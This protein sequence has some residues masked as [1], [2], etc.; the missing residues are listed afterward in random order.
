MISTSI[1]KGGVR[2]RPEEIFRTHARKRSRVRYDRTAE[3]IY[4]ELRRRTRRELERLDGSGRSAAASLDVS[5]ELV[6]GVLANRTRSGSCLERL[7]G[8][9]R[10]V[11]YE[12][13][14][15]TTNGQRPETSIERLL[16]EGH[17]TFERAARTRRDSE[18]LRRESERIG[19]RTPKR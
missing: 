19:K 17:E 16:A 11:Q 12:R 9:A 1:S 14:R 8:F 15:T 13:E 2:R 3:R 7:A 4:Q 10:G 18:R 6:A 5:I